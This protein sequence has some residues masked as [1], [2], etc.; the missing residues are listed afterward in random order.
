ME[1]DWVLEGLLAMSLAETKSLWLDT[2]DHI[3]KKSMSLLMC[4][5]ST[6]QN[7]SPNMAPKIFEL[8][9]EIEFAR[10]QLRETMVNHEL[11][12]YRRYPNSNAPSQTKSTMQPNPKFILDL[13]IL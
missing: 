5:M 2:S 13:S 1:D 10:Q 4:L 12:T 9:D 8:L 7:T 3:L 11:W 6:L